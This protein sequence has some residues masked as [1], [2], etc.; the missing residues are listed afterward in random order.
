MYVEEGFAISKHHKLVIKFLHILTI[1]TITRNLILK[2][3]L[4]FTLD[5]CKSGHTMAVGHRW[6]KNRF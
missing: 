2:E 5:K 1:L 4:Y 6:V 3:H